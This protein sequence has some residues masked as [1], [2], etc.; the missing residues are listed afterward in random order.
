MKWKT[1][2]IFFLFLPN[3]TV[4]YY[5][6][7]F[8]MRIHHKLNQNTNTI[9]TQRGSYV[10]KK[11]KSRRRKK[12]AA[13]SPSSSASSKEMK[14][15]IYLKKRS[16]KLKELNVC[17]IMLCLI[18]LV[19]LFDDDD[20]DDDWWLKRQRKKNG[21]VDENQKKNTKYK[22]QIYSEREWEKIFANRAMFVVWIISLII[23][24][25]HLINIIQWMKMIYACCCC[26][27]KIFTITTLWSMFCFFFG[28]SEM[29]SRI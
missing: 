11:R 23:L 26:W 18:C 12:K 28:F 1:K 19:N 29:V 10:G 3:D 22:R 20:D 24:I 16:Q 2:E 8:W 25:S 4:W 15:N 14:W 27:T 7:F 9:L 5:Y 13:S 21:V 17:N 6:Y